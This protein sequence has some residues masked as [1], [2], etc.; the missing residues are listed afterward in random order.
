M[1]RDASLG[2]RRWA[3]G[4]REGGWAPGGPTTPSGGSARWRPPESTW[5]PGF[6]PAGATPQV[7]GGRGGTTGVRGRAPCVRAEGP[8]YVPLSGGGDGI[9]LAGGLLVFCFGPQVKKGNPVISHSSYVIKSAK[10]K[11]SARK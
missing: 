3:A 4:T 6:P 7:L 5:A 10:N 11:F 8:V 9:S 1:S 2:S